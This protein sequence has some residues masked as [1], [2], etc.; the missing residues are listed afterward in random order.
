MN[1][2]PA[3]CLYCYYIRNNGSV[4]AKNE[5]QTNEMHRTAKT[6]SESISFIEEYISGLVFIFT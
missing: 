4:S 6:R 2:S 5:H 3:G 1:S